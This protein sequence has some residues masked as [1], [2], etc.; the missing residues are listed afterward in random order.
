MPAFQSH[1]VETLGQALAG[2]EISTDHSA[3][4]AK[5]LRVGRRAVFQELLAER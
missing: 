5:S 4:P 1:L 3:R 2:P